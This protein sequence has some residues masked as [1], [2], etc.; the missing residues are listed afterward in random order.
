MAKR[1][2]FDPDDAPYGHYKGERGST[3]SW[4]AA[5]SDRVGEDKAREILTGHNLS[6][7]AEEAARLLLG[8]DL[9]AVLTETLVKSAF[10][11][12]AKQAHPDHGGTD[13]QFNKL[14]AAYSLLYEL[15][16]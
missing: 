3:K 15:S 13:E 6:S 8:I 7:N 14:H 11:M 5:F 1:N 4:K 2:P 16:S 9:N 12:M 10:R